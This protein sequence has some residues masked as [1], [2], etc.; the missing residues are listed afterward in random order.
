[1]FRVG[2]ATKARHLTTFPTGKTDESQPE[3]QVDF[4]Y[5]VDGATYKVSVKG[6]ERELSRLT[7]APCKVVFYD[8]MEPKQ[9][10][11]LD[12]MPLG[13]YFDELTGRFGVNPLRLVPA[14]LLAALV[15]GEIVAIIVLAIWGF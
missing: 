8:P 5:Q 11:L 3:L 15:C 4:E 6:F 10:M 14:F 2:I 7:N 13:I 12:K 9:S 1:M